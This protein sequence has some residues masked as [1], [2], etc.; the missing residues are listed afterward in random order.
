VT[1]RPLAK[2]SFIPLEQLHQMARETMSAHFL[3]LRD[4]GKTR[5][6]GPEAFYGFQPEDVAEMFLHKHGVGRGVWF[7]LKDARVID[8][9]GKPSEPDRVWYVTS[10]H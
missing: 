10:A 7:R 1:A 4:A 3:R 2:R 5:A 9:Q 6:S 8:A